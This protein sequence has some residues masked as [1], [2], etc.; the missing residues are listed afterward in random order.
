LQVSGLHISAGRP[1]QARPLVTDVSMAVN[2]GEILGLVGESGSGKSLTALA[3]LGLLPEGVHVSAGQVYLGPHSV[4]TAPPAQLRTWRGPD[5][6]MIF[7]DPMTSMDPCFRVGRQMVEA[8]TEHEK[9]SRAAARRR[10]IDFLGHVGVPEPARRFDAFPHELSGGLRQ[11]VMIATALLLEPRVLIADE[12]TTALDVTTQASILALVH[13]LR[14]EMGMS[15]LWISHDLAVVAQLADR[16]A[17]MYAGELVET[18]TTSELFAAPAHH[19]T[20]GLLDCAAHG[21]RGQPFGYIDGT[22]PE[23][24]HWAT[25]CRFAFRCPRADTLCTSTHPDLTG[26]QDRAVRC[27][28]PRHD[29]DPR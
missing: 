23:P 21:E 15:V 17:V 1:G 19:Y 18:G 16:V 10:A 13:R 24:T 25:G 2:D 5:I 6:A 22:V 12:P 8:I 28:H 7:Q 26:P 29:Q 4:T 14:A 3:C 27:H 20:R 9:I 11:R